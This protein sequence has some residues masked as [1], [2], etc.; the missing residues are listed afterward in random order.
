M[1]VFA[2]IDSSA[3]HSSVPVAVAVRHPSL[4]TVNL[5]EM[6]FLFS[7]DKLKLLKNS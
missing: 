7:V 1:F 5:L 3:N 4:S 2:Q 6:A